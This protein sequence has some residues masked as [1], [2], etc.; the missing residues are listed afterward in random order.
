MSFYN[1]IK[2]LDLSEN[3][4]KPELYSNIKIVSDYLIPNLSSVN[5][6]DL[7]LIIKG[8]KYYLQNHNSKTSSEYK[9]SNNVLKLDQEQVSIVQADPDLNMRV[10]AGAGSGKTTTILCRVKYI[11]DNYTTPDR[12]LILTFNRDSAQNIRNRVANLFGFPIDLN[13]YTIDA[14]CFKLMNYYNYDS[15]IKVYSVSEYSHTGLSLMEKYG[16]EIASQYK[17]IFFDEFQDVNDVQFQILKIFTDNKCVLT[18]IGDDC[19]NIYQFRGTNN[20]YMINFDKI[21][22]SKTFKLTTNYRSISSIVELANKSIANNELKVE[23][24]MISNNIIK[25]KPKFVMCENESDT[26]D[27]ICKKILEAKNAGLEL[28]RIAVLSRNSYPLKLIETE[29]TK[30]EIEH[31]ACI[32]DKNNEDIK[33]ILVPNKIAVTTIHKSKGLEWEVVFILGLSHEHW[34]EH[35]NN[36][37]KNIEEERRLFYVGVTRAKALLYLITNHKEIPISIFVSEVF[38]LLSHVRY[39]NAIRHEVKELF[40]GS[41]DNSIVKESYGVTELVGMLS[42]EDINELRD[43]GLILNLNPLQTE[44]ITTKSVLG[45][46][47]DIKASSYEPDLGEFCDRYITRGVITNLKQEFIDTDTEYILNSKELDE[48][49]MLDYI[50][51][52]STK[53]IKNN[54]EI[55]RRKFTYPTNV[56]N[57]LN[58]SYMKTKDLQLSSKSILKEIYWIS[59]CRNFR[60]DRNRLAYKNIYKLI[61][62]N[63]VKDFNSNSLLEQMERLILKLSNTN[64]KCKVNVQHKFYSNKILCSICGEIDLINTETKNLIDLKCSENEY[65]LEWMVQ[66]LLYYSLLPKK[67]RDNI[68]KVSIINVF[69]GLIYTIDIPDHYKSDKL[70]EFMEKKIILDQSGTRPKVSIQFES[71][72]KLAIEK[73]QPHVIFLNIKKNKIPL[74]MI[75]DT[76]TSDF[77]GD[78]IQLSWIIINEDNKILESNNFYIKD[79]LTS[80]DSYLVHNISVE[81]LRKEGKDFY[82]VIDKFIE[83]LRKVSCVVGHNISYDLRCINKNLRKYDVQIL[84]SSE[85][86]LQIFDIFKNFDI[87]CTKK[88]SGGKSLEK[89]YNELFKEKMVDAHNSFVDVMYTYKCYIKLLEKIKL[90]SIIDSTNIDKK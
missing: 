81:K 87:V 16:K 62:E 18:V 51:K 3:L 34:P 47:E 89:L 82:V 30:R 9:F 86:Q 44:I 24:T 14:F 50:K 69:T 70:L 45:F 59:L 90:T 40:G 2:S 75:F 11:L 60:N 83:N 79:R 28:D 58:I 1:L 20:Y 15:D 84:E 13:I 27:Y 42:P 41:D 49:Q 7:L 43:Q 52:K 55:V 67:E 29:F 88:L 39:R 73:K 54:Q 56:L 63:L 5:K 66:L 38:N 8:F 35:L 76:E 48:K 74:T 65:R 25:T 80:R 19:Q 32:T 77:N 10:I 23:K 68:K 72:D 6:G 36:N 71:K 37:I 78:I 61:E 33:K 31:V 12:I 22:D 21:I 64:S 46:T 53:E 17:Y 57:S 4:S 26:I 85:N